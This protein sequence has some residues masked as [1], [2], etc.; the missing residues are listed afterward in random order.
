MRERIRKTIEAIKACVP[1]GYPFEP[2]KYYDII[3]RHYEE[4][5]PPAHTNAPA[6]T[7]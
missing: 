5:A 2:I 3:S 6:H 1:E 4:K 7:G